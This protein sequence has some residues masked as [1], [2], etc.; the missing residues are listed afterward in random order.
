V[1]TDIFCIGL[2]YREHASETNSAIPKNPMLFIKSSNT[3]NN[4]GDAIVLPGNSSMVDYEGELA[5]VI[6]KDAKRVSR[7]RALEYVLGYTIANDVSARDWQYDKDL[8]GGQFARGKCFDT[9]CP[10]GPAIVSK[11]EI[12]DANGLR[13]TTTLN[14]EVMQ[15]SSTSE[16]IF[17][18][19]GLIE[20]V[21]STLTLRAGAVILTGT[22]PGVGYVRKPSV[23]LKDGDRIVVEIERIGRLE[24]R[25]V[26]EG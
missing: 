26:S 2:N 16:M 6:G 21:S 11:D 5:V 24:N 25:V 3:L 17:D 22:P 19:P 13:I 1:P 4:P 10:M 18:V 8:G 7:Q 14:G 12:G 15:N 20:S 23:F 9:F